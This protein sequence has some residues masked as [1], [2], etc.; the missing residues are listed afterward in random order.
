MPETD[1]QTIRI[2]PENRGFFEK[3]GFWDLPDDFNE[4]QTE[5]GLAPR[6]TDRPRLGPMPV[7]LSLVLHSLILLVF[8]AL[9]I[10]AQFDEG[11]APFTLDTR[12]PDAKEGISLMLVDAVCLSSQPARSQTVP[13]LPATPLIMPPSPVTPVVNEVAPVAPGSGSAAG[14]SQTANAGPAGNGTGGQPRGSA[15]TGTTSFFQIAT[16]ARS[17]VYV[18]DRSASM[19]ING[20]LAAARRELLAS[21][22]RLPP[23]ARFQ[24]VPYNR[25]AEPLRVGGRTDLLEAT[26]ANI[27]TV[28]KLLEALVAEGGTDHWPALHRALAL[29]PDVIFF[30]TDADDLRIEQVRAITQLNHGRTAIHTIELNTL[31]RDREDMPL[32]LLAHTNQGQYQA[33]DVPHEER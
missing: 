32:H 4:I 2:T 20:R 23:T 25:F 30:L 17:V 14:V 7:I 18:I 31:N 21:L 1:I 12:A 24:V 28:A 33:V 9:A 29:Q 3:P 26:A 8:W 22:D 13:V 19:G 10:P 16:Q 27:Q 15:G 11:N 5:C 6:S